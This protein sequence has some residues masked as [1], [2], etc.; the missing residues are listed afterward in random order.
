MDFG[1]P[2]DYWNRYVPK[3]EGLT[4]AQLQAAA[5]KLVRPEELT[6]VVVGDLSK[7]EAPMRALKLGETAVLDGDGKRVR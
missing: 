1:L 4:P 2:D 3:V 7:I 5:A 6:W